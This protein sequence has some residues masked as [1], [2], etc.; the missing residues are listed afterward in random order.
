MDRDVT[1]PEFAIV[2]MVDVSSSGK[3]SFSKKHF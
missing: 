2:A 1:I 3:S